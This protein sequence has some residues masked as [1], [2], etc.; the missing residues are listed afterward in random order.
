MFNFIASR[1]CEQSAARTGKRAAIG[2]AILAAL[3]MPVLLSEAAAQDYPA[4]VVI[5][6]SLAPN[7]PH[8]YIADGNGGNPRRL[9]NDSGYDYNASL[10]AD[11][12]WVV[13]TSERGGSADIYRVRVDGSGLERLTDHPAFD[14]RGALSPDGGQLA[15][16]STRD[17]GNANIWVLDLATRELSNLTTGSPGDYHPT[18]SPDG[19][20]IAFSSLRD[21]EL[22]APGADGA[23][24][25]KVFTTSIYIVRPDGTGLRRITTSDALVSPS[26]S[27]DGRSI[28]CID[29][30]ALVV[31][32]TTPSSASASPPPAGLASVDVAFRIVSVELNDGSV[33]ELVRLDIAPAALRA[34]APAS[35]QWISSSTFAYA[36][37]TELRYS[38]GATAPAAPYSSPRWSRDG[39]TM[40][41]HRPVDGP[42]AGQNPQ[43]V[44]LAQISAFGSPTAFRLRTALDPNFRVMRTGSF[45]SS[46]QLR[47]SKEIVMNDLALGAAANSI[48]AVTP[49]GG[50]RRVIF[51]AAGRR[52]FAPVVSPDGETIAFGLGATGFLAEGAPS[53]LALVR[54]DGSEFRELPA[55]GD[56]AGYPSWSPDGTKLVY[57]HGAPAAERG[58]RILD[59]A[60]G[61]VTALTSGP[62]NFPAWSPQGDRIAFTRVPNG[63][64]G[65][66]QIYS[67]K[68][69]GEGLER[70]TLS[71]GAQDAHPAWSPDGRWIAFTSARINPRDETLPMG[72][73]HGTGQ[74]FVMRSDGTDV[75]QLIDTTYNS[76]T[77]GWL[78]EPR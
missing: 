18:W 14:D 38:D 40:V 10:S 3:S 37:G 23:V 7:N 26:W 73:H 17:G 24:A 53:R 27:P 13:F 68:S 32:S 76:G 39:K 71:P 4:E 58:L 62:D 55:A 15:F 28:I 61:R 11:G 78:P 66:S 57:V 6:A 2:S 22:L 36:A 44:T 59:V 52:A 42:I 54:G 72:S 67:V 74:I 64:G 19:G 25:A 31:Q 65:A 75:R 12:Q 60:S 43:Q 50:S 56:S 1:P 41:F 46:R 45:P 34:S 77:P 8:L 29:Q 51:E 20:V 5:Y 30:S 21:A 48:V 47:N 63:L 16:V 49:D 33:S 35:P 69:D 9:L 70:L